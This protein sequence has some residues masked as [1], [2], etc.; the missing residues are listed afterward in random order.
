MCRACLVIR[1]ML[2][3]LQLRRIAENQ[4]R[5]PETLHDYQWEGVAFLYRYR[6]A[7]LADEISWFSMRLSGSKTET[8]TRR[9]H[10]GLLPRK[11]AWALSATPLEND[12]S[13][14][15]CGNISG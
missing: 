9:W 2:D 7:L 12:E 1:L 5:V 11:R 4:L 10:A 3:S 6:S 14:W 8:L 15:Y 13:G